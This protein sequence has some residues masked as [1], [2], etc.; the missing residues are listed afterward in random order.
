MKD[1]PTG[2]AGTLV[3]RKLDKF[4]DKVVKS[5]ATEQMAQDGKKGQAPSHQGQ[6]VEQETQTLKNVNF[7]MLEVNQDLNYRPQTR[8]TKAIYDQIAHRI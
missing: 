2:E 7:G 6:I 5:R 1:L 3:G 8:E 4:G